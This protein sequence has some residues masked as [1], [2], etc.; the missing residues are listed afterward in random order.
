MK[1][2]IVSDGTSNGTKILDA[3]TGE[4]IEG[5]QSVKYSIDV[6]GGGILNLTISGV[7]ADI[8]ADKGTISITHDL[9]I[10]SIKDN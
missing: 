2:R 7:G 10:G 8:V 4:M 1:F 9:P 6:L 3:K 5:V